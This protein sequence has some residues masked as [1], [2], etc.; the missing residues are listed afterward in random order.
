MGNL[1]T[2]NNKNK[3]VAVIGGGISGISAA[4]TLIKNGYNV[5]IFEKTNSLTGV[6]KSKANDSSTLQVDSCIFSQ[7]DTEAISIDNNTNNVYST[8]EEVVEYYEKYIKDN[9][10]S[11]NVKFNCDVL[12]YINNKDGT[13]DIIYEENKIKKHETFYSVWI[14][15]GS[16]GKR[17]EI[18]YNGEDKFLGNI[19]YGDSNDT[20]EIDFTDKHV[21]VIG[22]G[23]F[24]ND[25]VINAINSG[26]KSVTMLVRN[27]RFIFPRKE[28]AAM[29]YQ[30]LSIMNALSNSSR[31]KNW[32]KIMESCKEK[33]TEAG[34]LDHY[35]QLIKKVDGYDIQSWSGVGNASDEMFLA[36][37]YNILD[38]VDGEIKE[39]NEDS[40]ITKDNKII[41]TDIIVKCIGSKSNDQLLKGKLLVDTIFDFH[42]NGKVNHN[43]N[44]D[45]TTKPFFLGPL[46][47]PNVFVL[48]AYPLISNIFDS[49][50]VKAMENPKSLKR[51]W[52]RSLSGPNY[53]FST[54]ETVDISSYLTLFWKILDLKYPFAWIPSL[55]IVFW[56]ARRK[57][58]N[59]LDQDFYKKLDDDWNKLDEKYKLLQIKYNGIEEL[60]E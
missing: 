36:A 30:G 23:A 52:R 57:L 40:I 54:I 12:E 53:E 28:I 27:R 49:V 25:N 19:A 31:I 20:K 22:A 41:K 13:V 58:Y 6:W 33:Y 18:T 56:T 3:T 35:N 1:C 45:H 4:T 42:S 51:A 9:N 60:K 10:L 38:I 47:N 46:V 8:A 48:I 44:I 5:V 15:T 37:K 39:L 29:G 43:V 7:V 16:L 34:L 21:T 59:Y 32:Q 2:H 50:C 17:S 26:A 55:A 14:R 11:N 24:A